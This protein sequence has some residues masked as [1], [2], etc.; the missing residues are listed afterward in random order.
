MKKPTQQSGFTIVEMI[1]SLALFSVV[2]TVSVGALLVLIASNE[3]FQEEQSVMTNLSFALDSMSR[4]I[5][6]GINYFCDSQTNPNL[7]TAGQ[8]IFD[9]GANLDF[10][11]VQ[12]CSDGND[13]D[14][15]FHGMSFI[16]GGESIT[17]TENTRIVYYHDNNDGKLYRRVSGGI[18]QSIVSSGIYIERAEF[19]VTGS[20]PTG[21]GTEVVQPTVTIVIEAREMESGSDNTYNIQTSIV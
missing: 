14:E 15:R 19:F 5:R 6:T 9:D 10:A 2:V 13:G 3:R 17:G 16:E 1:V 8:L 11:N 18:A 4:E 21:S 12:D 20:E 7:G